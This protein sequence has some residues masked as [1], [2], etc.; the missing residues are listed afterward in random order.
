MFRKYSSRYSSS[1]N[2]SS[3]TIQNLRNINTINNIN[4]INNYNSISYPYEYIYQPYPTQI[5]SNYHNPFN[6]VANQIISPENISNK[7]M[8]K[9]F[10]YNINNINNNNNFMKGSPVN[11]HQDMKKTNCC[12]HNGCNAYISDVLYLLKG[13]KDLNIDKKLKKEE[14]SEDSKE[15]KKE[16][17]E[18]K[19]KKKKK[20]ETKEE[21][22]K[23]EKSIKW[24]KLIRDFI[25]IYYFYS[26]AK[27]YS[28]NYSHIRNTQIEM[29]THAF[30]DEVEILKD[31]ILTIED[32]CWDEFE[33]LID[34]NCA[35]EKNDTKNKIRRESLKIIGI[36]KKFIEYIITASSKLKNIPER[37]QQ[38]LYE[39]IKNGAYFPKKYLSTFLIARLD[40]DFMG[41][42]RNVTDEQSAM[43]LSF[44]LLSIISSQEILSNVRET[45]K[46]FRNY[47][48]VLISA[49]YLAVILH[50]LVKITFK[51]DIEPLDDI[52]A[53]FNYYRNYHLENE[54][55]EKK[56]NKDISKNNY[57]FEGLPNIN[58]DEYAAYF[59]SED[60]VEIFFDTNSNFVET[61]KNNIFIWSLKLAKLIK[62][63]FSRKDPYLLPKKQMAKPEDKIYKEPEEDKKEEEGDN[64]DKKN[65]KEKNKDKEE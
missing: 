27:K 45:I 64:E 47:A 34:E 6:L 61:V 38:I 39:Y 18:K 53:L 56:E 59:L 12:A 22:K 50:G 10:S 19:N 9:R 58:E 54:F 23:K 29:R 25:H 32:L 37:I 35:F 31:W 49:K 55:I 4:N 60:E 46:Q 28:L 36:L 57:E 51:N 33:I 13:L 20:R 11:I 3:S 2:S 15:E 26:V 63:K 40:F 48:N 17:K 14:S 43:I 8:Q 5:S 41:K 65:N 44:L 24:W 52:F 30:E 1:S 62:D 7:Y 21:K 42:T 16:K